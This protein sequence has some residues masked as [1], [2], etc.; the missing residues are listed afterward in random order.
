VTVTCV[1]GNITAGA[2]DDDDDEVAGV[3]VAAEVKRGEMLLLL[4][5]LLLDWDVAVVV[6]VAV[7]AA[8][9]VVGVREERLRAALIRTFTVD[10]IFRINTCMYYSTTE[11]SFIIIII[12]VG[13]MMITVNKESTI[14]YTQRLHYFLLWWRARAND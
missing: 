9:G 11:Y 5:L 14:S 4:L 8:A 3:L 13:T 12:D 6:V 1:S 2:D 10:G 7:V